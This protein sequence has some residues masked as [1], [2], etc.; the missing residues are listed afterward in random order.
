MIACSWVG[1]PYNTQPK[2]KNVHKLTLTSFAC[3]KQLTLSSRWV[4]LHFNTAHSFSLVNRWTHLLLCHFHMREAI[5]CR[6]LSTRKENWLTTVVTME[7]PSGQSVASSV[8]VQCQLQ[9]KDGRLGGSTW[10]RA[11]FSVHSCRF[12]TDW[13]S[14]QKGLPGLGFLSGHALPQPLRVRGQVVDQLSANL[15][16]RLYGVCI[17]G[18]RAKRCVHN[19]TQN[20][21]PAASFNML[22][23]KRHLYALNPANFPQFLKRTNLQL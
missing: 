5:G 13:M 18:N 1:L 11:L 8:L 15:I 21:E 2:E 23:K 6:D 12:I 10:S 22:C 3:P 7:F 14:G 9:Y 17:L 20:K 19:S 4:Q 16:R